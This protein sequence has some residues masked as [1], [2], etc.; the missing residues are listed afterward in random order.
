VNNKFQVKY[1]LPHLPS[2][3]RVQAALIIPSKFPYKKAL[4]WVATHMERALLKPWLA[5][6]TNAP[7]GFLSM[8]LLMLKA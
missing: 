7:L 4:F 5:K 6:P 2:Q 8:P 1:Y 3:A